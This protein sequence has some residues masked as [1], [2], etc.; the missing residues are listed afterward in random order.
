MRPVS[1]VRR[2][3]FLAVGIALLVGVAFARRADRDPLAPARRCQGIAL[4]G[5]H[6]RH[7]AASARSRPTSTPLCAA[8]SSRATAGSWRC[9]MPHGPA[10]PRRPA[11]CRGLV[12]DDIPQSRRSLKVREQ[13]H[14]Y[15]LDYADNLITIA[16]IS[17]STARG[18][19]AGE[20]DKRRTRE[21]TATLGQI[22]AVE[23]S[24]AQKA[25]CT[26]ALRHQ[27]RD[28]R[29]CGR[30]SPSRPHSSCSSAHGLRG[31]SRGRCGGLPAPPP[32]SRAATSRF[33][34]TR[35][36]VPPRSPRS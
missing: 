25:S 13:L 5:R 32:T 24:R 28:R 33:A 20:E 1:L 34:W 10:C 3:I 30:R 8:T 6:G 15:L 35:A 14:G 16:Q 23:D 21:I 11:S 26:R 22:L 18:Q 17:R 9:S 2:V 7:T 27:V 31:A 29:R 4:E 12:H 36:V 19:A